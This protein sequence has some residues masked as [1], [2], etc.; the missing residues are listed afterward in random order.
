[1]KRPISA[2]IDRDLVAKVKHEIQENPHRH[3]NFSL[4]MERAIDLWLSL[5]KEEKKLEDLQKQERLAAKREA[6]QKA[7]ENG[8]I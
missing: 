6:R 3:G 7:R 4:A 8:N 5:V 2:R 1:M